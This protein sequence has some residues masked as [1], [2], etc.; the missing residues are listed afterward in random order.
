MDDFLDDE[1]VDDTQWSLMGGRIDL[2]DRVL[3]AIETGSSSFLEEDCDLHLLMYAKSLNESTWAHHAAERDRPIALMCLKEIGI[4]LQ[5]PDE[6][7]WTPLHYAVSTGAWR[8]ATYLVEAGVRLDVKTSDGSETPLILAARAGSPRCVQLLLKRNVP[9]DAV[10]AHGKTALHYVANQGQAPQL[11]KMLLAAGSDPGAR[12][13][14]GITPLHYATNSIF[15]GEEGLLL[16]IKAGAP[17]NAATDEG[18]TPVHGSCFRNSLPRL[19]HL[20][21]AG[22]AADIPDAKGL[23]S[24]HF[25]ARSGHLDC[26][27]YLLEKAVHTIDWQDQE[28]N[29]PLMCALNHKKKD[30]A[31][32][33]VKAGADTSLSNNEGTTPWDF[34]RKM[35]SSD[36]RDYERASLAALGRNRPNDLEPELTGLTL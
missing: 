30:C 19:R 20:L 32:A 17:L 24:M 16:L 26:L 25:A 29:T 22:A 34:I 15:E 5:A 27:V 23:V 36:I 8:A 33:L 18:W 10:D 13:Q 21:E 1:L 28:G 2:I 6:A 12:D 35:P 7:G 14:N 4:N 9:V 31:W 3:A 11:I